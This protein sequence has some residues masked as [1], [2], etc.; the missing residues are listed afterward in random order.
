MSTA[1][2]RSLC[3]NCGRELYAIF[4]KCPDC[5]KPLSASAKQPEIA[6]PIV[7]E[8]PARR[9]QAGAGCFQHPGNAVVGR[10]SSCGSAV[11][12]TCNIVLPGRPVPGDLLRI[13]PDVHLC[14]KCMEARGAASAGFVSAA[15][16]PQGVMCS[17]HP[18]VQAIRKCRL[19]TAPVCATCDF[20]FAG[21][22]HLCP[23]CA[24]AP[25]NHLSPKRKRN[26]ILSYVLAGISTAGTALSLVVAS[27]TS[28]AAAG[29]MFSLLSFVPAVAGTALA[30]SAM[31]RKLG[32]PP[33]LWGAAI[34]NGLLVVMFLSLS[35]IGSFMKG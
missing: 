5:G 33:A 1:T 27:Q 20:A 23:T 11:C 25:R 2:T 18:A 26:L 4:S 8:P 19:C 6:P 22:V 10:C 17:G 15:F 29:A 34:W 9:V 13:A 7:S 16:V 30:M 3:A 24:T 32:N 31:E 28:P 12:A 21:D 35:I 14:P